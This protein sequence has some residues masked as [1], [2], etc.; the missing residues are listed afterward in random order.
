MDVDTA[1]Y[2]GYALQLLLVLVLVIS[3]ACKSWTLLIVCLLCALVLLS[4]VC[5]QLINK[6]SGFKSVENVGLLKKSA[7]TMDESISSATPM[8]PMTPMTDLSPMTYVP[9]IMQNLTRDEQA[10]MHLMSM[11]DRGVN[12]HQ[13]IRKDFNQYI[14]PQSQGM[15]LHPYTNAYMVQAS[16]PTSLP[17]HLDEM[18]PDNPMNSLSYLKFG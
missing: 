15:N 10:A 18:H 1:K 12:M 13:P 9:P 17:V 4:I 6:T 2:F 16:E 7:L 3:L 8:P 11:T 5:Y 14:V